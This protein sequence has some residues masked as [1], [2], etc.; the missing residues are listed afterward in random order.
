MRLLIAKQLTIW[1][2]LFLIKGLKKSTYI[3]SERK[4]RERTRSKIYPIIKHLY[5]TA[6]YL[7]LDG[8]SSFLSIIIN[9]LISFFMSIIQLRDTSV[10]REIIGGYLKGT[11]WLFEYAFIAFLSIHKLD[12]LLL[13]P[14]VLRLKIYA[15]WGTP[16]SQWSAVS[17][18]FRCL[19]HYPHRWIHLLW[20]LR[21]ELIREVC[22]P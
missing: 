18:I 15:N 12:Y 19:L 10:L 3:Y 9:K 8:L 13:S 20:K 2:N 6:E 5:R 7:L 21:V 22:F 11:A 17:A 16:V 1:E 4:K 14:L